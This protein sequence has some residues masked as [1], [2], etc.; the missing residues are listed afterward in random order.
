[1]PDLVS[2]SFIFLPLPPLIHLT[3]PLKI[4]SS[5]FPFLFG[6]AYARL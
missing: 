2:L 1:V 5:S 6:L 3:H 4:P